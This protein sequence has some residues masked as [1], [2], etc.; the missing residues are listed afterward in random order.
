MRVP[1]HRALKHRKDAYD[2]PVAKYSAL[3]PDALLVCQ[4][5]SRRLAMDVRC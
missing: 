5:T 2:L 1:V 3:R 4:T